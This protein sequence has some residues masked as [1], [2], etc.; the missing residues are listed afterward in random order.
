MADSDAVP[1]MDRARI[2]PA[3]RRTGSIPGK[4]GCKKRGKKKTDIA[5]RFCILVERYESNTLVLRFINNLVEFF[6]FISVLALK[7][8][9]DLLA[10]SINVM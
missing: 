3:S 10:L 5:V 1:G 6:F 7:A 2:N 8:V 9:V 4:G